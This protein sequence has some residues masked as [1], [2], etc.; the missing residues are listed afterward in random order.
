MTASPLSAR[1]PKG[2]GRVQTVWPTLGR[3][4]QHSSLK[5]QAMQPCLGN[6]DGHVTRGDGQCVIIKR[7]EGTTW[8]Q[9]TAGRGKEGRGWVITQGGFSRSEAGPIR[10]SGSLSERPSSLAL[11][12]SH[13]HCDVRAGRTVLAGTGYAPALRCCLL[14]GEMTRTEKKM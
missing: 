9:G 2:K 5:K 7:H 1:V 6:Q 11:R 13:A 8:K 3:R 4:V 10:Q 14:F 12:P